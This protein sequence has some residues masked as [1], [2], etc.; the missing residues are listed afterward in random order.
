MPGKSSYFRI[1]EQVF[2]TMAGIS[3][4]ALI[5]LAFKYATRETCLPVNI[6]T[7]DS[8]ITGNLVRFKAEM[9]TAKTYS[10]NFGDGDTK[11]EQSNVTAHTYKVPGSYSISVLVNGTCEG[12]QT[13]YVAEAQITP[14]M[15]MK[16]DIVYPDTAYTGQNI[17]FTDQAT[18]STSWEWR[19]GESNTVDETSRDA[20]HAFSTPGIK[21]IYLKVNG[22]ADLVERI[23]ILVIEREVK[24]NKSNK[25]QQFISK[26][27]SQRPTIK[28]DPLVPEVGSQIN[29]VTPTVED[30]KAKTP[31]VS[32]SQLADMIKSVAAGEK[33]PEIFN[34]YLCGNKEIQVVYNGGKVISFQKFC[35]E[36]KGL[37]KKKIKKISVWRNVNAQTNCIESMIVTME[38]KKGIW[39]FN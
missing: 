4:I 11:D 17:I 27:S 15:S 2:F 19:F 8:L 1:D 18:T 29:P 5:V 6:S 7:L 31:D 20:V 37:K 16:P 12:T 24:Q 22:R 25:P 34:P 38:L 33:G 35:E 3:L 26:P 9:T 36:L 30:V 23:Q 32:T 10:W 21:N 39:P 13:I 14:D 28:N